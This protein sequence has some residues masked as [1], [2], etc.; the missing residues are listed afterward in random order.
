MGVGLAGAP[1]DETPIAQE[2]RS[3]TDVSAVE[4]LIERMEGVEVHGMDDRV[5]LSSEDEDADQH[6]GSQVAVI[7]TVNR[8]G[9]GPGRAATTAL[10]YAA[11]VLGLLGFVT[12]RF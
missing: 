4:D 11:L 5:S 1:V 9:F 7:R 10:L 3:P 2:Q 6:K 12:L 8:W